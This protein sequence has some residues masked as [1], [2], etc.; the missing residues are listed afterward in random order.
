MSLGADL[1]LVDSLG[2]NVLH[3]ACRSGNVETYQSI[4]DYIDEETLDELIDVTTA[5]GLT[6]LMLAVQSRNEHLVLTLLESEF[7][8]NPFIRDCVGKRALDHAEAVNDYAKEE[9]VN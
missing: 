4:V 8:P 2:Y 6:P 9:I 5:G 7:S 1:S 3:Y